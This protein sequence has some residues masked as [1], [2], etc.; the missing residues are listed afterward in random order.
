MSTKKNRFA[1][2]V[3]GNSMAWGAASALLAALFISVT[4]PAIAIGAILGVGT[5]I[6]IAV[7][8]EEESK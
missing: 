4:W 7:E 2:K 6:M 8:S 5:G 1:L 3:A